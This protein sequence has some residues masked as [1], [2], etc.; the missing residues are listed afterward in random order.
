M[1]VLQFF[2]LNFSVSNMIQLNTSN[3]E[4]D[5]K[6]AEW[7]TFDQVSLSGTFH[8]NIFTMISDDQCSLGF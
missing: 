3:E 4:L 6:I 5:K 1:K 7:L 2:P 8:V